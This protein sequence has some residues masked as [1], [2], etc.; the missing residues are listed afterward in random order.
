MNLH[1][2]RRFFEPLAAYKLTTLILALEFFLWS[3][4]GFI[5]IFFVKDVIAVLE[6]GVY[7]GLQSMLLMYLLIFS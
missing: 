2:I 3:I 5:S 7:E 6:S 4:M 1:T